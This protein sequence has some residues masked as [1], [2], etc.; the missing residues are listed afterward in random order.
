MFEEGAP[1]LHCEKT[2]FSRFCYIISNTVIFHFYNLSSSILHHLFKSLCQ[3]MH[4]WLKACHMCTDPNTSS[5]HHHSYTATSYPKRFVSLL[6]RI[7]ISCPCC[8]SSKFQ[9]HLI[10]LTRSQL[11]LYI[12]KVKE[13]V[14]GYIAINGRIMV[15]FMFDQQE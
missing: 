8:F 13:T 4:V 2:I 1:R 6:N 7:H 11:R 5:S 12:S 10:P 14:I 9:H 15:A 3:Y